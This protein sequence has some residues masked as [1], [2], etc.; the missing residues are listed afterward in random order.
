M[1]IFDSFILC[2]YS[3]VNEHVYEMKKAAWKRRRSARNSRL[4]ATLFAL[5]YSS[6][7]LGSI[8]ER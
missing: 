6:Y 8:R 2:R 7:T 3:V 1:R 5:D 4:T